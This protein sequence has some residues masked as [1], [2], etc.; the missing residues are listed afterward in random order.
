M[1]RSGSLIWSRVGIIA[2]VFAGGFWIGRF[3]TLPVGAVSPDSSAHADSE[4]DT[5]EAS[6]DDAP[7]EAEDSGRFVAF[8]GRLTFR[9]EDGDRK[10]DRG[11]RIIVLPVERKGTAKLSVAGLRSGDQPLLGRCS[12]LSGMSP[13]QICWV[14]TLKRCFGI[15]PWHSVWLQV[16]RNPAGISGGKSPTRCILCR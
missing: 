6:T 9:T 15:W 10:A 1:V 8:R 12:D 14:W 13:T 16:N 11:A 7:V 4:K 5:E 2:V 3:T